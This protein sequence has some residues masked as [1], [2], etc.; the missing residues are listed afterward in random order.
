MN[1]DEKIKRFN[2]YL[3]EA[4]IPGQRNSYLAGCV[5]KAKFYEIDKSDALSMIKSVWGCDFTPTDESSFYR[6]WDSKNP[7]TTI[8]QCEKSNKSFSE[9]VKMYRELNIEKEQV[10]LK[11]NKQAAFNN[12]LSYVEKNINLDKWIKDHY[13]KYNRTSSFMLNV[14]DESDVVWASRNTF[15]SDINKEM[16]DIHT[17]SMQDE[18]LKNYS[19]YCIN[20]FK[21][22][23]QRSDEEI[24]KFKYMLFES[25][26]LTKKEQYLIL[27]DM[28]NNGVPI[29]MITFSGGKSLHALIKLPKNINTLNEYREYVEDIF[30][31][32]NELR[33]NM[34]DLNC[35]NPSRLSRIP[36][37]RYIP[38]EN[39]PD[40]T[41]KNQEL[42]YLQEDDSMLQND[43]GETIHQWID[44]IYGK[45]KNLVQDA[46]K[47][48][49]EI[50][51][52]EI[53]SKL[54]NRD[55]IHDIWQDEKD[56]YTFERM[57]ENN[58]KG[59]V[60]RYY[61]KTR[62][63]AR[64]NFYDYI[65]Q[66]LTDQWGWRP[67]L[68]ELKEMTIKVKDAQK[69]P[70]IGSP[71]THPVKSTFTN[72]FTPGWLYEVIN[73]DSISN[74]LNEPLKQLLRNIFGEDVEVMNWTLQWM[75]EFMHTFDVITAPVFWEIPGAGKS[76]FTKAFGE[77]IGDWIPTPSKKDDI[78]F[79]SWL[80]N[81]VI[82]FEESSSGS[83]LDG[84]E[85]G[86]KLKDWITSK[87]ITIEKKGKD[88]EKKKIHHC[89]IF[90]AN[91]SN[92]I[93]PV[94]IEDDDRRY[95][96]IK[97]NDAR[98]LKE[99]W[100]SEDFDRWDSGEYQKILM[101]WI[102]NLPKD[103]NIDIRKGINNELKREIIDMNKTNVEYAF[104]EI[105]KLSDR[106]IPFEELIDIMRSE[107]GIH[108]VTSRSL[109]NIARK[110]NLEVKLKRAIYK[111]VQKPR[112]GV[113]FR[114]D[115]NKFSTMIEDNSEEFISS[116][117]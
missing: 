114:G 59:D 112:V 93:P 63:W 101:K 56:I 27:I 116:L 77:A 33:E 60:I 12:R 7:T 108:N 21:L 39:N 31:S 47:T 30:T 35:K 66:V 79:N 4:L 38:K 85:L 110:M 117:N 71:T 29:K 97:N 86:D 65:Q 46:L 43:A 13:K 41:I 9:H 34:L 20:P 73:D 84:K 100:S 82:I 64:C 23:S 52:D 113:V 103:K 75:R 28:I 99:I 115:I 37:G 14:F 58:A 76:M 5:S 44:K 50:S 3:N 90:N 54:K 69:I 67:E 87:Y 55:V 98:N 72:V 94:F 10:N 68:K 1:N 16:K 57:S 91:I 111:G 96:I 109:G 83:K 2:N 61:W 32:L 62:H 6:A 95:T 89:F 92:K 40:K 42:I 11:L 88:P 15:V 26:A 49:D 105:S 107:H 19:Y 70:Y 104:E 51:T 36:F 24:N 78:Q 22:G 106:F 74:A 17:W 102:Y 48:Q 8:S 18:E 81:T 45:N 25:D 80:E 53:L